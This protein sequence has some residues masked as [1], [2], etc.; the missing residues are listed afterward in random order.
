MCAADADGCEVYR[1]NAAAF[2]ARLDA[3]HAEINTALT[4]L[5]ERQVLFTYPFFTYFLK[6]YKLQNVALLV[7]IEGREPSPRQIKNALQSI[8]AAKGKLRAV[9][10]GEQFS[11]RPAELL[12]ESAGLEIIT[13][14][15]L[16][17]VPGRMG[18]EELM[19]YNL[20][21]ILKGLQ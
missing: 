17:G 13:L 12:S 2:S 7:E 19:R 15:P 3:L 14:D 18:Y 10:T 5:K 11:R 1:R 4:P 21:L 8:A 6:R 9:F 20:K 16:G